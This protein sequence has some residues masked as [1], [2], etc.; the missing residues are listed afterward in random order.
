LLRT[1]FSKSHDEE[2]DDDAEEEEE[3]E[4]KGEDQVMVVSEVYSKK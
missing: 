1:L 4:G 2:D 3:E